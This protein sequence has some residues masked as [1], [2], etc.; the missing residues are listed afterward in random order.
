MHRCLQIILSLLFFIIILR[1]SV[2]TSL[3]LMQYRIIIF[4]IIRRK[5]IT[6]SLNI[7][8]LISRLLILVIVYIIRWIL[9][10]IIIFLHS[11][12]LIIWYILHDLLFWRNKSVLL[13]KLTILIWGIILYSVVGAHL[14]EVTV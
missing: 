10:Y 12:S 8:G 7:M 5:Y 6:T 3:F 11:L 13:I 1:I 2:S 9:Y 14:L 4:H